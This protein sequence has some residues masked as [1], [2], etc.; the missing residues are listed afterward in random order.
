[1]I[2]E[3]YAFR[4][5]LFHIFYVIYDMIPEFFVPFVKV[6]FY[7]PFSWFQIFFH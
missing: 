3:N 1:M 5:G 2:A 4:E 6:V 7:I